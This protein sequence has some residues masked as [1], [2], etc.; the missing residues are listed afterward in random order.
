MTRS[1][2]RN[3]APECRIPSPVPRIHGERPPEPSPESTFDRWEP[4]ASQSGEGKQHPAHRHVASH[5][6]N[7]RLARRKKM[8]KAAPSS[9]A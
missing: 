4:S 8:T 2:P 9:P 1:E 7:P 3:D 5:E 6:R